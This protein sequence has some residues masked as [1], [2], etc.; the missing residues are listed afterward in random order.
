ML[1]I[2][3][4][5]LALAMA[6]AGGPAA[7]Q[8]HS[9]TGTVADPITAK[10]PLAL[11]EAQRQRVIAAV[12]KED[13]LDKLPPDFQPAIGAKIPPQKKL[14]AHPLPRPLVYEIPALKQYYYARL[15]QRVLIIDPTKKEV[16]AILQ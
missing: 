12:S 3:I 10:A 8:L 1:R 6:I 15:P 7:A 14:A 16:V 5:A 9:P 4:A 13:T 11:T 2:I